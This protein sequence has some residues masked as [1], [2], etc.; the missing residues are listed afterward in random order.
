MCSS[1]I[2]VFEIIME[3]SLNLEQR[4]KIKGF[5]IINANFLFCVCVTFNKFFGGLQMHY[6]KHCKDKINILLMLWHWLGFLNNVYK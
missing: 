1:I 5:F 2:D 3:A 6:H 4:A